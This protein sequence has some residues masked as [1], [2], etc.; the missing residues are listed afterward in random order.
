[1]LDLYRAIWRA[2]GRQQVV[3]II[4]SLLVAA[5][6]A[7]PLNYQKD[8]INGLGEG[9]T[10]DGLLVLGAEMAGFI[11]LSLGLKWALG[12]QSAIVGEWVIKRLRMVICERAAAGDGE[13]QGYEKG[14]LASMISAETEAVGKV[15][16]TAVSEPVLQI[17]TLVSVIGYIAAT[18]PRLGIFV[19]LIV[20][21][22]AVI[23][24]ATQKRINALVSERVLILRRSIN[25]ITAL[26]LT[27][28]RDSVIADFEAIY[29]SRR[30]VFVWKL[31]TKF[32][33]SA[34]NG[35]GLVGLLVLG[36][37]LVI[38]GR[39]DVGTLVAATVG[40]SRIQQ[41]WRLIITFY[42]NLSAVRVQYELIRAALPALG[43]GAAAAPGPDR[44]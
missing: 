24:L 38:E 42:R 41:P 27:A 30:K 6:A 35:A 28:M 34:L 17:G 33:L 39:S 8:I 20:L 7:V 29:E 2:T 37:W 1:M 12:Y 13:G 31:S 44:R 9:I 40:L 3:M 16:G 10:R 11:L 26:Q 43:N 25:A 19:L 5:L 18:Q 32:V 15:V 21:P 36:G 22:Q 14:A 4:L 23:V